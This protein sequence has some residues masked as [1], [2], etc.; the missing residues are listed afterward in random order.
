MILNDAFLVL[1]THVNGGINL[2]EDLEFNECPRQLKAP[3]KKRCLVQS[4]YI[5][6]TAITRE[7]S[8]TTSYAHI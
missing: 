2:K 7:D 5:N 4:H 3:T 1:L 6:K 8:A